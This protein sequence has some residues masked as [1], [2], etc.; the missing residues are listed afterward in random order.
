MLI[1]LSA[2]RLSAAAIFMT[3]GI[4][5][6]VLRGALLLRFSYVG[7]NAFRDEST[8]VTPLSFAFANLVGF[9]SVGLYASAAV[10]GGEAWPL[11][12]AFSL[13]LLL[14]LMVLS[15]LLTSSN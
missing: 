6:A 15:P 8:T 5:M 14:G 10:L 9:L 7:V 4:S 11:L 3:A 1:V 2:G 12:A 13:Q